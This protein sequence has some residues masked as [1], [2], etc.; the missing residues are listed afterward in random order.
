GIPFWVGGR[1]TAS[2]RRAA[3]F[4][5]GWMPA[6]LTPADFRHGWAQLDQFAFEAGRDPA[7][8]TGA[9]H[10]FASI[11]ATYE[12]AVDQ[13][14]PGIEAIFRAPFANFEP[15]CLVGTAEQWL[16]Q[17]GRFAEAGV[18]HVNILLYTR[19]LLGDVQLI[20]EQ[21]IPHLRRVQLAHAS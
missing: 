15:L 20:G 13:L 9:I 16:E 5:A 18:R 7:D 3:R 21:V 11:G 6:M 14:A 12:A 10:I 19:D 1:S 4:G 2:L 17:I 8:I